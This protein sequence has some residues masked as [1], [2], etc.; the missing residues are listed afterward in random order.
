MSGS[1]DDLDVL[2]E[3]ARAADAV[4]HLAFNHDFDDFAEN[5]KQ[6]RLAIETFGEALAGTDK[7]LFVTSGVAV[8]SPGRVATEADVTDDDPRSPRQSDQAAKALADK[9]VRVTTVRLAPSVHGVGEQ[10]GFVPILIDLAREKGVSAYVGGGANRWPAVH[11]TD[12]VRVYSLALDHG[13]VGTAA[14]HAVAEEGVAFRDIAE[15]IG[16][17]LGLPVEPRE[18]DHFGWFAAFAAGDLPASSAFTLHILGWKPNG[19]G[20]LEDIASPDYYSG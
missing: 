15:A 11:V 3:A 18:P 20:L 9:G 12:A 13:E 8:I 1:L 7:R 5:R 17:K 10:H 19:P 14:L 16:R 4:L 2:R 6:D